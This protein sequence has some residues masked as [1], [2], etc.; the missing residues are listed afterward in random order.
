[1]FETLTKRK[2][3]EKAQELFQNAQDRDHKWQMEAREDFLFRDGHQWSSDEKQ[4]LE[5]ELRPVLTFNLTKASIDL[6]MGLN[7]DVKIRH[8]ATAVDP[9]DAFLAEVINDILEWLNDNNDFDQEEDGALESA[10]ISGRGWVAI[11]FVADPERFG[12]I[13]MSEV[14]VPV[15][16]IH[17]DPSARRPNLEDASYITWDKW[18]SVE[19]FKIQ[20]PKVSKKKIEDLINQNPYAMSDNGS[21]ERD[22]QL[23]PHDDS[24]MADYDRPM[25]LEYYDKAKGMIRVVH[26]EYWEAYK[27]YFVFNPEIGDF[28]EVPEK[29]TKKQQELFIQEFDEPMTI[30]TIMDKKVKWLQFNGDTILFDDDSPLPYKGFSIVPMFAFRDVSLRTSNHYGYVRIIKDPQREVNKRW[31]QAL[32]MLNQ[33]VQPGVYAETSAFVDERQ[34][35][36][37]LKEA[38]AITWMNSGSLQGGKIKERTV[39]TF[40]NAPMQMEEASQDIMKKITGINPDLLGQDRGRQEPGVVVR[41]RQQQ[42]ITLLKP[43]FRNFNMMKKSLFKRQMGI[44]MRYMP[45]KQILRILGENDRYVIQPGQ[46]PEGKPTTILVD[47]KTG[48]SADIRDVRNMDFNIS[49]EPASGNQTTRMLELQ[50]MLEMSERVPVPPEQLIEKLDISATEKTRWLEY[51]QNQ[52]QQQSQMVEMQIQAEAEKTERELANMEQNTALDFIVD[53]AKIK[54]M[55]EKDEKS[56]VTN[57]ERMSLEEKQTVLDFAAEM[58][59]VMQQEKAATESAKAQAKGAKNGGTKQ[60]SSKATSS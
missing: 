15:H 35:E 28:Q 39:P 52:N 27:R 23:I 58:A 17:F 21:F 19:D 20:Y 40:P 13:I 16:E 9:S 36:Q 37:S 2:K 59:K 5:D 12:E 31:S 22:S 47:Q 30:E 4:I 32:N 56:L 54:Q 43:L 14:H 60:T 49:A 3:L 51:I 48:L 1:M 18:M 46:T 10:A 53:M 7:E 41:L 24:P 57:F 50:A 38:G 25:D 33:Q 42:G 8:R 26:M 45:D 34:A 29:P 44:V 55:A 11:D 6:I